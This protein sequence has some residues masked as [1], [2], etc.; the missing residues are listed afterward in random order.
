MEE[1]EGGKL[2]NHINFVTSQVN[3][4]KIHNNKFII[5]IKHT[6]AYKGKLVIKMT[7]YRRS[8]GET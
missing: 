2:V 1:K 6:F 8:S 4:Q 5:Q 3:C 7:N